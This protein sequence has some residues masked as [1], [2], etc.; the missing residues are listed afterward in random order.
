MALRRTYPEEPPQ[1]WMN[2]TGSLSTST[3]RKCPLP[4]QLI[5]S[6]FAHQ[7]DARFPSAILNAQ[8]HN[9]KASTPPVVPTSLAALT[10]RQTLLRHL[11]EHRRARQFRNRPPPPRGSLQ[12]D[13]LIHPAQVDSRCATHTT[14]RPS[15][16]R[17]IAPCTSA[18]A[19]ESSAAVASSKINIGACRTKARAIAIR[20]RCPPE[21]L[22][23]CSPNRIIS[24]G[25]PQ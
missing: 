5:Q 23:P 9:E 2:P 25:N 13:N 6:C 1:C 20:C 18:S 15:S 16:K 4:S 14:V 7:P 8:L 22:V 17:S 12:H 11:R 10:G 21:S 24:S 3:T 19:F